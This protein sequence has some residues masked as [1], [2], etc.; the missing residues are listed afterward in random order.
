MNHKLTFN[1]IGGNTSA[2]DHMKKTFNAAGIPWRYGSFFNLQA[3]LNG[4]DYVNV[5]YYQISGNL[6]G[7]TEKPPRASKYF[8]VP[9]EELYQEKPNADG[10]FREELK[11]LD[12]TEE[13]GRFLAGNLLAALEMADEYRRGGYET[14]DIVA[15]CQHYGRYYVLCR[16][17]NPALRAC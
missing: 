8:G 2:A 6:F 17:Y 10:Y 9:S 14:V 4:S 7:I 15:S 5:E 3:A 1:W 16:G 13:P 11:A 12:R